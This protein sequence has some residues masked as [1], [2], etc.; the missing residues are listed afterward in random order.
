MAKNAV[1]WYKG[2]TPSM[3]KLA[4]GPEAWK[5]SVGTLTLPRRMSCAKP[6]PLAPTAVLGISTHGYSLAAG[7]GHEQGP[8]RGCWEL[9]PSLVLNLNFSFETISVRQT[10]LC[11]YGWSG[12][13]VDRI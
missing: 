12:T 4:W 10:F 8:C 1:A 13:M 9:G 7:T 3:G 2:M 5:H 6:H 11:T